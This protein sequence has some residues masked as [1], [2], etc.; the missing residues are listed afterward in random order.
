MIRKLS[1]WYT[2]VN[3][4]LSKRLKLT[5]ETRAVKAATDEVHRSV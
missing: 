5:V 4:I 3:F 1:M 2:V